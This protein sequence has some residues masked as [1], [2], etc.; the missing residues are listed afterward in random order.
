M[1]EQLPLRLVELRRGEEEIARVGDTIWFVKHDTRP[2][3]QSGCCWAWGCHEPYGGFV[4]WLCTTRAEAVRR[5]KAEMK[6]R[7]TQ[8]LTPEQETA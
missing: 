7:L 8:A 4:A 1:N 6:T 3:A 5:A 2:G